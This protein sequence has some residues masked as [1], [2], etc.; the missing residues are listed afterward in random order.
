MSEPADERDERQP[1]RE[2]TSNLKGALLLLVGLLVLII[3]VGIGLIMINQDSTSG[4][5]S[6]MGGSMDGGTG[7]D[8]GATTRSMDEILDGD[9]AIEVDPSGTSAVLRLDTTIDVACSVIYGTTMDFG[10]IATDTDMAGGAHSTHQPLML[11]LEPGTTVLW[12]VQG[13]AAD[14]TIYVSEVGQFRTP[15]GDGSAVRPNLALGATVVET[16]SDF[17]ESFAGSN[18]IDGSLATEWSSRGDGDAAYIVID[19]GGPAEVTGV[20]FRTREMSD[21]TS[22]TDAYTVTIDGGEPLGPFPAGIGLTVSDFEAT[23]QVLRFDLVETTGGNTGA[24]EIEIYGSEGAPAPSAAA[25]TTTSPSGPTVQR[26]GPSIAGQ[27]RIVEVSS[28]FSE[29]F[30]A[31]NAIDGDPATEW[32]SAGDGDDAYIVVEFDDEMLFSGVGFHTREMSD[33]T[34]ITTSFT[35][36]DANG[37]VYGPF[38]SGPGLAIAQVD[39]VGTIVRVDVAT[40]TGGNT[41]AVEIEVYGEPEM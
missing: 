30:A 38:E 28:E 3:P 40:S 25:T 26:P 16:S 22:I 23:G 41:G 21:G 6:G 17:S 10:G 37:T 24:V 14:G 5:N 18:A 2:A 4:D 31:T 11:D 33:G 29:A 27:G 1:H 8:S 9:F 7:S 39:F 13:T 15:A 36:T 35:V 32:S 19:L 34:S 20:G 12:R